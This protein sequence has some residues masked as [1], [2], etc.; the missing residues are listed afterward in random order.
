MSFVRLVLVLVLATATAIGQQAN[1]DSVP[2]SCPVTRPPAQAFIPPAPYQSEM[3]EHLFR[4]GTDKLWIVL[5]DPEI[6]SWVPRQPGHEQ[7]VQPLTAKVFW[8][9]VGYDWRTEPQPYLT[10]T[11]KRLDGSAPPLV[12]M[13]WQR[14]DGSV[15]QATNAIMGSRAAMLQ[16][17][18]V[19]TP[20]C[21]EVTGDHRGDKLSFVVWVEP[22][23]AGGQ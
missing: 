17:V 10:I 6:W 4:L 1:V 19:P 8:W 20:G 12:V 13:T 23:K 15:S 5:H 7:D 9:S 2:A 22:A 16:G 21:W 11:G 18:Y 14:P 3:P